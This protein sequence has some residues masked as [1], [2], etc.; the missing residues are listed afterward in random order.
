MPE[1]WLICASVNVAGGGGGG[2][3][4]ERNRKRT[5]NGFGKGLKEALRKSKGSNPQP[6]KK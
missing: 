4:E 1:L 6:D 2:E 3:P 5:A